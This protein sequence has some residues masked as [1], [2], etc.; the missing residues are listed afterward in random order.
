[1]RAVSGEGRPAAGSGSVI[2][3]HT[4][5]YSADGR[6]QGAVE[7]VPVMTADVTRSVRLPFRDG[8]RRPRPGGSRRDLLLRAGESVIRGAG[9]SAGVRCG[10]ASFRDCRP[11]R[12]ESS[13]PFGIPLP[14]GVNCRI[15]VIVHEFPTGTRWMYPLE[16]S[17][18]WRPSA[19]GRGC[20]RTEDARAPTSVTARLWLSGDRGRTCWSGVGGPSGARRAREAD[21]ARGSASRTS[22]RWPPGFDG[23]RRA[24]GASDQL[25]GP[26]KNR[27][28][29]LLES[30][31]KSARPALGSGG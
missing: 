28:V 2:T 14:L 5:R 26:P 18:D 23:G 25:T 7:A 19:T 29:A 22:P 12:H 24:E 13:P 3:G 10:N 8:R 9:D 17:G 16:K 1:M 31:W 30:R 11:H 4:A 27:A 20:G 6:P 15:D 21:P